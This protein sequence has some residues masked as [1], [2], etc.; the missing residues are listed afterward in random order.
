LEEEKKILKIMIQLYCNKKH[1]TKQELCEEC[2]DLLS[3]AY[4]RLDNCQ[5]GINKGTCGKCKIHC[6][7]PDMR[8]KIV[9]VMRFSGPRMLYHNPVVVFKHFFKSVK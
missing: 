6:Y 3:Y 2:N 4:K 1:D 8:E 5:F 9:A 7:K